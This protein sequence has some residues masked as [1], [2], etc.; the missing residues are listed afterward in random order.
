MDEFAAQVAEVDGK[1]R[2]VPAFGAEFEVADRMGLMPL[3]RFAHLAKRGVDAD[4]MDGLA[5]MYDVLAACFTDEAW[6]RFQAAAVDARADGDAL[7]EVVG[8]AIAVM[9]ARPTKRPSVS[10]AGPSTTT[11][12]STD[13][14]SF[15]ARKRALGLVPVS[16]DSV[17]ELTA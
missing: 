15:A 7:L 5:A 6:T 11:P 16:L 2:M 4:D 9:T 10:P 12:S 17:R 8:R 3:L 13:D 1:P 14:S